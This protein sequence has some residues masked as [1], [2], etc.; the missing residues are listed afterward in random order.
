V[1]VLVV[2]TTVGEVDIQVA[3]LLAKREVLAPMH[4][5]REN[6]LVAPED[7]SRAVALVDVEVDDGHPQVAPLRAPP[8]GLHEARGHRGVVEYAEAPALV[9]VGVMG[10]AGDVRRQPGAEGRAAGRDRGADRPARTLHHLRAPREPD[11][12]HDL[13][14]DRAVADRLDVPWGVREGEFAVARRLGLQQFQ[15]RHLGG[16]AIAQHLVLAHREA[17]ARR[18]GQDELRRVEDPHG[19]I[20]RKPPRWPRMRSI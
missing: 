14:V 12:A 17:V 5:Q 10:P 19:A 13:R 18:Q 15:R 6:R 8:L 9:R 7:V 1:Q 2:R 20:V 4:G 16:E 11:F 3:R